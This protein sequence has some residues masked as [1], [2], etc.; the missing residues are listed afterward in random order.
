MQLACPMQ[1]RLQHMNVKTERKPS[2]QQ[3]PGDRYGKQNYLTLQCC[4]SNY[5]MKSK[6]EDRAQV[7][8][9]DVLVYIVCIH[10]AGMRASAVN[11]PPKKDLLLFYPHVVTQHLVHETPEKNINHRDQ[12]H[13]C[14][15]CLL[16]NYLLP[17]SMSACSSRFSS[18]NWKPLVWFGSQPPRSVLMAALSK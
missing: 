9:E 3:A 18:T 12:K 6:E 16:D 2:S 15:I 5:I 4:S 11:G 13:Y 14:I 7:V 1:T 8:G 10:T 17:R